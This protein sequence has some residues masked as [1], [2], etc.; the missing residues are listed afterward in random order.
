MKKKLPF[1]VSYLLLFCFLSWSFVL[2][3]QNTQLPAPDLDEMFLQARDLAL[4]QQTQAAR[5]LCLEI[6]QI[7]AEYHEASILLARTHAWEQS[8]QEAGRMLSQVLGKAPRNQSA[9]VAMADVQLWQ[10]NYSQAIPFLDSALDQDPSNVDLLFKKAQ[11]L[12]FL[13]DYTPA[14]TLLN[15]IIELDPNHGPV[16]ELLAMV[17]AMDHRNFIGLGY[18]GDYFDN[19][20]PWH[21][22]YLEYG[23]NTRALGKVIARVNYASRF[24]QLGFQAEVDAYPVLAPEAYLYLNAGYSPDTELFPRYR[25][26]AEIFHLLPADWEASLGFRLLTF[27][28]NDLLILTGSISKYWSDYYF[29]FRPYITFASEG[30][31]SQSYFFTARR[32]F[33]SAHHHLSLILGTGF[34]ADEEALVGGEIYNLDS[35]RVLMQYQ[36]KISPNFLL[37]TGAGYQR[38]T[39]GIWGNKYTFELGISYLF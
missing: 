9:L 2:W 22:Y 25:A 32:Y 36:Q 29:S 11:A 16:K 35:Q 23:R 8:Y 31:G 18:R 30:P 34:S 1:N 15:K 7:N 37:R 19:H 33:S 14:I 3:G 21:L 6:L 28:D 38:Y 24:N 27:A 12:Y 39:E 26:G 20:S 10:G 5:N 13:E 17:E 4:N